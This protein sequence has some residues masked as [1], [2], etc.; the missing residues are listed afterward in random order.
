M[1]ITTWVLDITQWK[2][3]V[4]DSFSSLYTITKRRNRL[5]INKPLELVQSQTYLWQECF[6][7]QGTL[8]QYFRHASLAM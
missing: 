4:S 6:S 1:N 8:G 2:R 7:F 3:S 5:Q